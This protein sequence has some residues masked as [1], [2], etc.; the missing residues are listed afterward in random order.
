MKKLLALA[1]LLALLA[2]PGHSEEDEITVVASFYPVYIM[3]ANVL[4]GVEGV[5]LT[6]MTAPTTGCLHDYQL[7]VSDMRALAQADLFLINGAGMEAFLPD[8]TDQ[9]PSL[10]VVDCSQG[11]ALLCYDEAHEHDH[12]DHHDDPEDS[13]GHDHDHGEFNPHIW[14]DPENAVVMTGNIAQA[15]ALAL[16]NQAEKIQANAEAY[17]ARLRALDEELHAALQALP[18]RDIVTFH[19]S[20]PYFA[21][22]YGLHIAAVVTMEPDAPL[23]PRMVEEVVEKVRA[24][25]NP[26][27][28]AEPQYPSAAL[29]A[30]SLETGAPVYVMDPLSTGTGRLTDYEDVLRSNAAILIDALNK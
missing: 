16:P 28:F 26:P 18:Q 21:N 4:E 1:L 5:Q 27:L 23:S 15:L 9:F 7:L 30:I 22:A 8:V 17:A 25:G 12:D 14:L 20:F 11:A 13:H 3:A 19:E 10:L 2:F 6:S 29:R 24:A